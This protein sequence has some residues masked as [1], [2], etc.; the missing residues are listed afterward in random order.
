MTLVS[1]LIMMT[2]MSTLIMMD[3][4]IDIYIYANTVVFKT[5]EER[6]SIALINV[7]A[8]PWVFGSIPVPT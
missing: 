3:I 8:P 4:C 5:H 7:L 2:L 6:A 1:T